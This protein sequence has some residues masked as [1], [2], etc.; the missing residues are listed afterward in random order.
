ML[1]LFTAT[2][3]STSARVSFENEVVRHLHSTVDPDAEADLFQNIEFFGDIIVFTGIGLG[4]HLRNALPRL[5]EKALCIVVDFFPECISYCKDTYFTFK[6]NPVIYVS[7]QS[8]LG[9]KTA[10]ETFC[11]TTPNPRLQYIKHPASF[12]CCKEFYTDIMDTISSSCIRKS[13][14]IPRPGK[15]AGLFF[16]NFFLEK[17]LSNAFAAESVVTA[18][19]EYNDY[20]S[21]FD[22]ET[23]YSKFIQTE[24]PDFI[25]SVNMKGF[26][27]NG[28]A[29]AAA[30]R[31]GIPVVVW[32]VDDPR[33]ILLSHKSA[34]DKIAVALCWE[35]R[36]VPFLN[37]LGFAKVEYVPLACDPSL[38]SNSRSLGP[39]TSLGFVGT[40][41]VDEFAGKIKE[42]FLWSQSYSPLVELLSD[43]I[44][45]TKDV[46]FSDP[47][48]KA[49]ASLGIR[50]KF[51]DEKN[52]T[53]LIS[54]IT[55]FASMKKRKSLL[56]PLMALGLE[57]FGDPD[58]WKALLGNSVKTHNNI[59]YRHNIS[60]VY[61]SIAVNINITS[62]QMPSAVN[63]RVFDIPMAHGFVLSDKQSDLLELFDMNE[64]AFFENQT[65]LVDMAAF[66]LSH[67]VQR[68]AI[69]NS[70]R[71]RILSD[72]TYVN[73]VKKILS[74]L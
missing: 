22:F 7:S 42:K 51:S 74:L 31:N 73:R 20:K 72:H 34:I 69:T 33:P 14:A 5:P 64:I 15:K 65:E 17:E 37:R 4:W 71:K 9:L 38:F 29:L 56:Q 63:Q 59:D 57:T 3:G 12:F 62:C 41:M 10:L 6:P 30:A 21:N 50:L 24:N 46:L 67:E 39:Q 32:F 36:F 27:A 58:G 60:S 18:H 68:N 8:G 43:Q 44:I 47:L 48:E 55:H 54:Y 61:N 45:A 26:D 16:G 28:E 66:Y 13:P 19:F 52:M 70:A 2:N 11:E 25:I 53:W 23:A 35:K 40:A 1:Q 49:A